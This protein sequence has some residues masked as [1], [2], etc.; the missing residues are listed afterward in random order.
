VT[1][2]PRPLLFGY[3]RVQRL[4]PGTTPGAISARFQA[5]AHAEGYALAGVFLDQAHTAPAAFD[6]LIEAVKQYDARAVAV[7]TLDHLAVLGKQPELSTFLQRATGAQV[8]VMDPEPVTGSSTSRRD[9][10]ADD[11]SASVPPHQPA[12]SLESD[13]SSRSGI[14][15]T[16]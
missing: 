9:G 6:A 13:R 12:A 11:G 16:S 2:E 14:G 7:P 4:A 8:L 1:G 10:R 5:Y 3:M 15:G